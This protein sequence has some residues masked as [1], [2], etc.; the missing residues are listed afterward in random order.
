MLVAEIPRHQ[1]FL[2]RMSPILCHVSGPSDAF[3][4]GVSASSTVVES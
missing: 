3:S 2:L 1:G 4:S